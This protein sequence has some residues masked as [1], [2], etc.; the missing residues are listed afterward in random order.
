MGVPQA[1]GPGSVNLPAFG[2]VVRGVDV[3]RGVDVRGV[4]VTG[5]DKARYT[6]DDGEGELHDVGS[7]GLTIG[8]IQLYKME[9]HKVIYTSIN[10]DVLMP[11]HYCYHR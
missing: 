8:W 10:S 3:I 1:V 2:I 11:C 6:C 5:G 9:R 7:Q 4:E